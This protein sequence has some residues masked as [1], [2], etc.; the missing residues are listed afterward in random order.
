MSRSRRCLA[1]VSHSLASGYP[2]ENLAYFLDHL[3]KA[4]ISVSTLS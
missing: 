2:I 1:K 4:T 3:F